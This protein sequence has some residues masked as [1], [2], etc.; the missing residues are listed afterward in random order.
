MSKAPVVPA[1]PL[2]RRKNPRTR[3]SV[4]FEQ[5][6]D[7]VQEESTSGPSQQEN[8]YVTVEKVKD[9]TQKNQLMTLGDETRR[10]YF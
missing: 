9:L 5:A 2:R 1:C 4:Q 8:D 6:Q 10:N 7:S 3:S